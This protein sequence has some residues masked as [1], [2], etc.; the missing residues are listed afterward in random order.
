MQEELA[1]TEERLQSKRSQLEDLVVQVCG[2][3]CLPV[4]LLFVHVHVVTVPT[5]VLFN[6]FFERGFHTERNV[7]VYQ[8]K[9]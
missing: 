1:Q 4:C 2:S 7:L 8:K 5:I 3:V 6:A 9:K